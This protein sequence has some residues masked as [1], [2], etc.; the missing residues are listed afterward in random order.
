MDRINELTQQRLEAAA[1]LRTMLDQH[2]QAARPAS[3]PPRGFTDQERQ[4]QATA[5]GLVANLDAQIAVEQRRLDLETANAVPI[6]RTS[7]GPPNAARAPWHTEA[8]GP[9]A[10]LVGL[11]RWGI[12]LMHAALGRG[13]D[14]RLIQATASGMGES[15]GDAGGWAVPV[16]YAPGIERLMFTTGEILSRVDDRIITGNA[17]SYTTLL[18]TSRVDGS[19]WGGV[20]GYWLDEGEEKIPSQPRLAR[21][22]LKLRKVAALGYMTDELLEDAAALGQELQRLFAAEL[23]FQVENKIWRGSGAGVPLGWTVAPCFVVVPKETVP[24]QAAD[25]I[26]LENL[27]NMWSRMPPRSRATAVWYI[28][29]DCEPQLDRLAIVFPDTGVLEPRFVSY[30][31]QGTLTIKGRP[32]IAVEYAESCGTVGDIVLADPQ[33][34]RLIRKANGIQQASSIHV[35]F[36]SDQTAFRAVYRVDGQPIPRA[37]IT[38]YKGTATLSPFIGLETR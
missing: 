5:E 14:P 13:M 7:V 32:V 2:L 20:L 37:P 17:I 19:R 28:N 35:K 11:G 26:L 30:N 22:E 3:A 36:T 33:Q 18:E 1:A 27:S 24:A 31:A 15:I 25:T 4:A 21:M 9:H 10:E 29:Q 34:Y 23:T 6:G 12:A 8:D 16:E 38:P